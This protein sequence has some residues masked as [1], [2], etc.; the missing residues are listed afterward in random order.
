MNRASRPN[1]RF[2]AILKFDTRMNMDTRRPP[3]PVGHKRNSQ[4]GFTLIELVVVI[5]IL[6]ILAAFA[7]PRFADLSRSARVATLEGIASAMKST[8]GIIRAQAYVQGLTISAAN[9]GN[10]SAYLV[11]TEAGQSE[12]DWRNL[13]PESRA[14]L[15]DALSMADHISLD[16]GND[17]DLKIIINNQYTRVGYDIR[18]SGP[19]TANGCYVTYNSFGDPNCTVDVVTTDC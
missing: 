3:R 15:G 5:V 8:I 12:I 14:E 7:L 16:V 17:D 9:P 11:R 13:C 6:G 1:I 4:N 19:P 2:G 10:Q 18:G